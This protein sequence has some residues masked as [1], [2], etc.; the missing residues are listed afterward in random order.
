[1]LKKFL[2]GCLCLFFTLSAHAASYDDFVFF[3]D[4]LSDIGNLSTSQSIH[5]DTNLSADKTCNTWAF[6]IYRDMLGKTLTPSAK[7]GN[8][9]A[10]IGATAA[11]FSPVPPTRI[12]LNAQV[13]NYL[14]HHQADPDALYVILIG[15]NDIL[16]VAKPALSNIEN[17]L[18]TKSGAAAAQAIYSYLLSEGPKYNSVANAVITNI[19]TAVNAL[20]KK[21]AQHILVFTLP[22][23]GRMPGISAV[24]SSIESRCSAK[25]DAGNCALMAQMVRTIPGPITSTINQS[26]KQQLA[27]I[28]GVQVFDLY[29]W[30][31]VIVGDYTNYGSPRFTN[32][33]N[34]C[35]G[36]ADCSTYVFW[37]DIHPTA[38][39]HQVIADQVEQAIKAH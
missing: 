10:V 1:M 33:T 28:S 21:G 35:S 12:D 20:S 17:I 4:S 16:Y 22:D 3:G 15:G 30:E 38:N 2:S 19:V 37:N 31:N 14:T 18:K 6:D 36:K 39:M 23:V 13:N 29:S 32:N 7:G 8:D 27:N 11:P 26:L 24:A 9:Y 5:C 25:Y 34:Y